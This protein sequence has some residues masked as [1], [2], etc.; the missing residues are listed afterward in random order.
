LA[1]RRRPRSGGYHFRDVRPC[2]GFAGCGC[3][4]TLKAY[5]F[6]VARNAFPER[7]RK[8]KRRAVLEDVYPD[9]APGPPEQV[10]ARLAW[11]RVREFL[12]TLPEIDRA[13]FLLRV[14]HEL[15]CAEIARILK[16]S[17][18]A[19]KVKIHRVRKKLVSAGIGKEVREG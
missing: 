14:Q 6:A 11:M 13:A 2:L 19:V 3:T 9:P 8:A 18:S 10:E 16:I 17:L 1:F 12:Q 15:P 4:E 5:L 7:R